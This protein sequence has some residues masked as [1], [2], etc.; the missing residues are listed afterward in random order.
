M[1][2]EYEERKGGSFL[3]CESPVSPVHGEKRKRVFGSGRDGVLCDLIAA[4]RHVRRR[5][6]SNLR[7]LFFGQ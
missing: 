1:K 5:F 6:P 3:E 7:Q 2:E 4:S